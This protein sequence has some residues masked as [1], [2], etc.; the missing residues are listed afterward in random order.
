MEQELSTG[1][2]MRS[3]PPARGADGVGPIVLA[4]G[5][6]AARASEPQ[7]SPS[8]EWLV[9]K[10]AHDRPACTWIEVRYRDRSW[11]ALASCLADAR[12]ALATL[13]TDAPVILLGFSMGGGIAI[14]VAA[15]PRVRGVIGLAPWVPDGVPLE[16]L[17]GKRLA[18]VHGSRDRYLPFLPGVPARHSLRVAE[19]V[20]E[21]GSETSF[22][23]IT[24]AVHAIAL[25]TVLGLV[26]LPHAAA[27]R[28]AVG[29][30]IDE[31]SAPPPTGTR[32][33][34]LLASG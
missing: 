30:A 10:L 29:A 22:T 5:G 25:R 15:D 9:G 8:V 2:R 13:P 21:L 20:R 28:S 33:G 24:G 4:L 3:T 32:S 17:A 6:S 34:S 27:W 18:I 19:R 23:L 11:R 14:G 7:W 31:L 1:A 12:A 16:Q 26:P